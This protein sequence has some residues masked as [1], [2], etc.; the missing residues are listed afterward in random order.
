MHPQADR[1]LLTALYGPGRLI[2][3]VWTWSISR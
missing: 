2:G 1:E 3:G